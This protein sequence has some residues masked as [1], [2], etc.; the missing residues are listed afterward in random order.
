MSGLVDASGEPIN[1]QQE[2]TPERIVELGDIAKELAS[3]DTVSSCVA[4]RGILHS[5]DNV[6]GSILDVLINEKVAER[7]LTPEEVDI[8]KQYFWSYS[9]F[10]SS[11]IDS[12]RLLLSHIVRTVVPFCNVICYNEDEGSIKFAPKMKLPTECKLDDPGMEDLRN[13]QAEECTE[14]PT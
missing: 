13:E 3:L 9:R 1:E 11:S 5:L 10:I 6:A 8:I 7:N 2:P 4:V 14:N 12:G